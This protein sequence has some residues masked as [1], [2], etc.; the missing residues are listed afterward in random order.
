M[1]GLI[2]ERTMAPLSSGPLATLARRAAPSGEVLESSSKGPT[3][4]VGPNAI[5]QLD[6]VLRTEHHDRWRRD[7]FYRA[8]LS[9][10]L[11][12]P[13]ADMVEE[14]AVAD[15]Y[16][17]L[18]D[19]LPAAAARRIAGEAG[20]LTACYIL[21]NRIPKPAQMLLK[22]LPGRWAAPLLLRAIQRHAWTFAGSGEA[23]ISMKPVMAFEIAGNP[24]AMPGCVWHVAV[25]E[26]LFRRL[27]A[28]GVRVDHTSCC[29]TGASSCRFEILLNPKAAGSSRRLAA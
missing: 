8:G 21:E 16:H 17:A 29:R 11:L 12:N 20:R 22:A 10:M 15:L 4:K 3:A 7:V 14:T 23:G 6:A 1:A 5:L 26:E 28:P 19:R 25:F 13:P 24:I 9:R 2:A 27:V 18:F